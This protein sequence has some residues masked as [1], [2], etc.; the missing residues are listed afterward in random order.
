MRTRNQLARAW[1]IL[2]SLRMTAGCKED[3]PGDRVFNEWRGGLVH[4]DGNVTQGWRLL[5]W[6][7]G[8]R[9]G[10]SVF[11]SKVPLSAKKGREA[12][13]RGGSRG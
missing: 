12:G 10:C 7:W 2:R 4:V 6:F 13:V 3:K 5:V 11:P 8:I 9:R 1:G